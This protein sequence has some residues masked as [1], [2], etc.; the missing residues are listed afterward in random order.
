MGSTRPWS[1]KWL[2]MVVTTAGS[3]APV[4]AARRQTLRFLRFSELR[5]GIWMRPDNID[6]DIESVPSIDDD[7]QRFVTEPLGDAVR[8]AERLWDFQGWSERARELLGCLKTSPTSTPDDLGPG[9]V[10][11]AS[12]LRHLQ[13]DPL[14]P[15]ELLPSNWPGV[16]LRNYY[17]G[18]DRE[19]RTLLRD[20]GRLA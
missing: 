9:F 4:R 13:A 18:W 11:S 20:W 19:Y 10:L 12:V 17:D 5:E 8:L 6:I 14:L 15:H 16:E 7:I 2:M 3:D 1:G